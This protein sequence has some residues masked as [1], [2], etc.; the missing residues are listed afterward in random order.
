VATGSTL[1]LNN[2]TVGGGY[3]SGAFATQA[4][5]TNQILAGT[6]SPSSSLTLNG[7]DTVQNFVLNGVVTVPATRTTAISAVT[8]GASGTMTVGG[9][10]NASEFLSYGTIQLNAGATLNHTGSDMTLGGG[11]RTFLATP[12]NTTGTKIDLGGN[13]LVVAGGYLVNN[14]GSFASGGG[15]RNGTVIVDYGSRAKGAGYYEDVLTQNGGVF[16]PGNSPGNSQQGTTRINTGGALNIDIDAAGPNGTNGVGAAGQMPG[17][18]RVQTTTALRITATSDSKF[19]ISLTSQLLGGASTPGPVSN[20]D[21]S[22]THKWEVIQ[23]QP[24]ANLF[25]TATGG[26]PLDVNTYVWDSNIVNVDTNA[27]QNSLDGGSFSTSF[28]LNGIG[29]RSVYVNFTPNPV[30]EPSSILGMAAAGMGLAGW[31]RRRWNRKVTES[32]SKR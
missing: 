1:T 32:S 23:M 19:T 6:Q 16:S 4:G 29:T 14:G 26:T 25:N 13:S 17:W 20:F 21:S 28:D 12:G 3:L 31:A 27:F 8:L 5:S 15:I 22:K 10:V 9:T 30:P 11:S 7:A 2:S 24:G 18:G